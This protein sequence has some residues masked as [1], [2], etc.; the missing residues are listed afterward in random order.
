MNE[1]QNFTLISRLLASPFFHGSSV[2]RR[3]DTL[4]KQGGLP[5]IHK[6]EP[7]PPASP[8]PSRQGEPSCGRPSDRRLDCPLKARATSV[9]RMTSRSGPQRGDHTRPILEAFECG[10]HHKNP[11]WKGKLPVERESQPTLPPK[12]TPTQPRARCKE[13]PAGQE[14]T[15]RGFRIWSNERRRTCTR[16]P[17]IGTGRG[18]LNPVAWFLRASRGDTRGVLRGGWCVGR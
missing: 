13:M 11:R 10:T 1:M 4:V 6:H 7:P 18:G 14:K 12:A 5:R 3:Q 2:T 15:P 17:H 8:G 16:A 9:P